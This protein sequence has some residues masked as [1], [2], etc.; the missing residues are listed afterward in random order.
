MGDKKLN[1]SP[2]FKIQVIKWTQQW[3]HPVT[4]LGDENWIHLPIID[5]QKNEHQF[6]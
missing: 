4:E 5:N 1:P 2:I 3:P 6:L